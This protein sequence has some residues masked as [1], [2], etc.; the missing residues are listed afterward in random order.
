MGAVCE[1][2]ARQS[3][4]S[5][6]C[7]AV[8]LRPTVISWRVRECCHRPRRV[9]RWSQC[10]MGG[11]RT[12]GPV[13]WRPLDPTSLYHCDRLVASRSSFN[14]S[15]QAAQFRICSRME[16]E[17]RV[18]DSIASVVSAGCPGQP[19]RSGLGCSSCTRRPNAAIKSSS[20]SLRLTIRPSVDS[21]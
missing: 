6:A 20:C 4:P 18:A 9:C 5:N 13:R 11:Q 15:R 17:Q 3:F 19:T 8:S 14:S 12:R 2:S 7:A 10:V 1:P 16:S 21:L